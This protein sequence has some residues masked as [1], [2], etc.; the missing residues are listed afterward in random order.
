MKQDRGEATE[1]VD[2]GIADSNVRT[3]RVRFGRGQLRAARRFRR[4]VVR[5]RTVI[6]IAFLV[7]SL[8][9]IR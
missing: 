7:A 9:A 2:A 1:T 8:I 6:D 5:W 4:L 3:Q